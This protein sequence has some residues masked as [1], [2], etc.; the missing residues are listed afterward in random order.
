[1]VVLVITCSCVLAANDNDD[2]DHTIKHACCR[3]ALESMLREDKSFGEIVRK[4]L[5]AM[6]QDQVGKHSSLCIIAR[7]EFS[8][9]GTLCTIT[10]V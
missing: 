9:R 8:K 4:S 3:V 5:L 6:P 7:R 10:A 2:D 1:M